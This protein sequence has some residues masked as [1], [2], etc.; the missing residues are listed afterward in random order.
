MKT[1]DGYDF[2]KGA[3]PEVETEAE[4]KGEKEM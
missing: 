3:S 1:E 4:A 2:C